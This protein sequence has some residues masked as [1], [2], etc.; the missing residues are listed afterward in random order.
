[1][2]T[3]LRG[4]SPDIR[5]ASE[6]SDK[7]MFRGSFAISL[8]VHGIVLLI[9]G[10]IVIVPGAVRRLMPVATVAPPPIEVPEPP[11]LE[12]IPP[13]ASPDAGGSPI[14]DQAPEASA[15][16][17]AAQMDALVVDSATASSPRLN[18]SPGASTITSNVFKQGG[19]G[20]QGGSGGGTGSGIGR[21][22]GKGTT[23][24]GAAQKFDNSLEGRFFDLKQSP[25][26]VA[27]PGSP[28]GPLGNTILKEF[29]E[30]GF[31]EVKFGNKYYSPSIH[32][33]ASHIFIPTIPATLGPKFFNVEKTVKPNAYIIHYKGLVAPPASGTYR[34]MGSADD[35]LAVALDGKVVFEGSLQDGIFTSW[36][37]SSDGGDWIDWKSN[38]FKR[39]DIVIGERPGGVS[40]F[41]LF[42]QEQG[43]EYAKGGNGRP[44]LPVFRV[45]NV[46]VELPPG[47]DP[48]T[49]PEFA[50]D[51][52][53]FKVKAI[54]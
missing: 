15:S 51:G 32:L 28:G 13:D 25:A 26:R 2:N 17:D 7:K 52:P 20:G 21:G 41:W 42:I 49:Y 31:D 12:E 33:F 46:K 44:V 30:S 50:Q 48:G 8:L 29:V 24:F 5:D 47:T 45:D 16:Q 3:D 38:D 53:V 35:W 4:E 9:I 23:F 1:M 19:G 36:K 10:S 14:G 22:S 54:K 39:L 34:F 6:K 43:R 11:K 18:A 40:H 37:T 27:T